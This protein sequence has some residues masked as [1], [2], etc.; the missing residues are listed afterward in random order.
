MAKLVC[1]VEYEKVQSDS[2]QWL[3]GVMVTCRECGAMTESCGQ[4][5]RSINRCLALMRE[6]CECDFEPEDKYFTVEED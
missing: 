6:E 4:T 5:E 2:G 1:D 3:D